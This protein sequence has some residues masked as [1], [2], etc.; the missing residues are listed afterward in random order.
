MY[1]DSEL[2]TLEKFWSVVSEVKAGEFISNGDIYRISDQIR[3]NTALV[4][5]GLKGNG[6]KLKDD[7]T[8]VGKNANGFTV[9]IVR[10]KVICRYKQCTFSNRPGMYI[11]HHSIATGSSVNKLTS[12]RQDKVWY[13]KKDWKESTRN[14]SAKGVEWIK[15]MKA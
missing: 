14:S 7:E 6:V 12:L 8:W 5:A 9:S 1:S 3:L 13:L 11:W 4:D 15:K 2:F 10:Y